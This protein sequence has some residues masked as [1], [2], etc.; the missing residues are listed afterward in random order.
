MVDA[1]RLR[2]RAAS[3]VATRSQTGHEADAI[4]LVTSW[5][6]DSVDQTDRWTDAMQEVEVDPAYPG[7]EVE[8]SEIPVVAATVAGN[9]PGPVTV[10][11]GHVDVVPV[12][13]PDGWTKDP[14]GQV[15]GDVLYGR[16]ACDMKAGV[17]A[18]LEAFSVFADSERDFAGEI[19]F[20]AVPGEEDGG[21]GT[22]AAIRRGWTGDQVIITEPTSDG[23][24]PRP[25]IC[26][27]GALTFSLGVT[28]KSAHAAKRH[29]GV[30]ALDKFE[31]VH[32]ALRDA[33]RDLNDSEQH[34]LMRALGLPYPTTVG[35]IRGGTWA[36]NVMDEL[37]AEIR[38]GVRIDETVDEAEERFAGDIRERVQSD[39]WFVD[40]PLRIERTG[41]A[42]GSSSIDPD[43]P[44][45]AA[46][47]D[48]SR[49]TDGIERHPAGAPYGCDMAMWVRETGATAV[50]FGPGDVSVAHAPD[51]YVD[52]AEAEHVANVL[53]ATLERLH[54]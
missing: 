33:E 4:D 51:E 22:L 19:R 14:T 47:L 7:R 24:G 23:S 43:A 15:H 27:G 12:G 10:L 2:R 50:V 5:I 39:P 49:Q 28:G 44:V 17:V 54:A 16:G 40:H 46:L 37:T 13:D 3:L 18:A 20:V 21:T 42:F 52:L 11:T 26:H 34:P 8:R 32:A 53:V 41:A 35:V 9:R 29:E 38:V 6:P 36:S 1:P 31:L 25:V 48:A 45:V 30:S